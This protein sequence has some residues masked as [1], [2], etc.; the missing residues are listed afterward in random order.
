[1][2]K[3]FW[4]TGMLIHWSNIPRHGILKKLT[5]PRYQLPIEYVTDEC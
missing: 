2:E 5:F 4:N 3:Y 1:M